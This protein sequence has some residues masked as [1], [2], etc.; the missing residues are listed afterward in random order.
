MTAEYWQKVRAALESGKTTGE[1]LSLQEKHDITVNAVKEAFEIIRQ[2]DPEIA[3]A[4]LNKLCLGPRNYYG[5][6]GTA[7]ELRWGE[8]FGF[9]SYDAGIT[10][11]SR[12]RGGFGWDGANYREVSAVVFQTSIDFPSFS[13]QFISLDG[14][15]ADPAAAVP[16][17]QA[18]MTSPLRVHEVITTRSHP[19]WFK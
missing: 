6:A 10:K 9:S 11:P 5:E 4:R 15:L 18:L 12:I 7:I 14:F 8:R 17:L 16:K 13:H 3:G 19:H 1:G 2:N